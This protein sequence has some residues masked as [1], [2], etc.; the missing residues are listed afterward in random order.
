M[1]DILIP[2][3]PIATIVTRGEKEHAVVIGEHEIGISKTHFDACFHMHFLN[4]LILDVY[5]KGCADTRKVAIETIEEMG[6]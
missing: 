2:P 4:G 1:S 6:K 5:K 3:L